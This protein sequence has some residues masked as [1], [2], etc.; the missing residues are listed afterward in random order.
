MR[1]IDRTLRRYPVVKVKVDSPYLC[2]EVEALCLPDALHDLVIGNVDG[3]REDPDPN[4]SAMRKVH[5]GST[6]L[7]AVQSEEETLP[8]ISSKS[9]F[10]SPVV[11]MKKECRST[12]SS[13]DDALM[14]GRITAESRKPVGRMVDEVA[15]RKSKKIQHVRLTG[16]PQKDV[17]KMNR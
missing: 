17:W 1:M 2:G 12:G 11:N 13:R 8:S 4:W 15:S 3:A 7:Q 6:S 5:E 9:S 16:R 10:A 14:P